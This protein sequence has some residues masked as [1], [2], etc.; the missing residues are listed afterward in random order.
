M[1]YPFPLS[2][3]S[4]IAALVAMGLSLIAAPA[5][6]FEAGT[7]WI[8]ITSPHRSEPERVLITY[9]AKADGDAYTLGADQLWTGVPA[10]RNATPIAEK[11]PLVILSHGSGGNA[12][13]LGWLSTELARNGFIVAAPNHIHSTS[14]DSIPVE[15]FKFWE[16]AQ[17]I[18]AL[19]DALTTDPAWS[20][21][22][23][24]ARIGG[25]GFSL[26]GTTMML[27]AGGRT[28]L[29]A[30]EDYCAKAREDDAGCSWFL[31]GGVDFSKVDR[32]AF[33]GDYKDPRLSAMV[34]VDPG[35]TTAYQ[36]DS[37]AA[38]AMPTLFVNLGEG[39]AIMPGVRAAE[40]SRQIEGANYATI[41]GAVHFS[42][43]GICNPGGPELLKRYGEDPVCND[44]G[45]IQ[46]DDLHKQ[47]FF[48]IAVFLRRTLLER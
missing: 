7:K 21:L 31:H 47:I 36:Q 26:G 13:G 25:I 6:S 22:I 10:R 23:D 1:F 42:F 15:S 48:K 32:Q 39:D 4:P 14:G 45:D 16:R 11:F 44:G 19:I 17:D 2:L 43:L 30:L 27:S 20:A 38:I 5:F 8:S 18:S 29:Q 46:R 28:S 34:A 35:F 40:L 33:E 3:L 9:P 12:A 24:P 41:P 37:I